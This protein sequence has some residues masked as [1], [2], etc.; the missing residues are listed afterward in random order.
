MTTFAAFLS[1]GALPLL[2]YA[3]PGLE[4]RIPFMISLGLVGAVF[5]GIGM[6][7]SIVY[8]LPVVRSGLRT[9][10]MGTAAAGLAFGAGHL[11]QRLLGG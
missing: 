3:I 1:V 4:R 9:L 7:K 2:P 6:L 11:A 10:I 5:L 8:S